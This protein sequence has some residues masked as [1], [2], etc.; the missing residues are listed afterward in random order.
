MTDIT[1]ILFKY[2]GVD[3]GAMVS[4]FFMIY[5]LGNKKAQG[6]IFG[7]ITS[8][9]WIIFNCMVQSVPGVFANV[10]FIVLN[11]RSYWKWNSEHTTPA[12]KNES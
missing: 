9:L 4:T 12:S 7:V 3:W 5:Y 10:V 11:V 6:F 1:E 8:I 2:Y